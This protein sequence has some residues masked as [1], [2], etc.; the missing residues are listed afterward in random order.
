MKKHISLSRKK[1]CHSLCWTVFL[2]GSLLLAAILGIVTSLFAITAEASAIT[3]GTYVNQYLYKNYLGTPYAPYE[4]QTTGGLNYTNG[5]LSQSNT[6]TDPSLPGI[7]NSSTVS[8]SSN[9]LSLSISAGSGMSSGVSAQMWDTLNFGIPPTGTVNSNTVIGTLN[10]TVNTSIG[11]GHYDALITKYS[12]WAYNIAS[13]NSYGNNCSSTAFGYCGGYIGVDRQYVTAHEQYASTTDHNLGPFNPGTSTYSV[14]ITAGSL[15][16]GRVAYIAA[17]EASMN[18][19][20]NLTSPPF[21]IDP[22]ITISGLLPGVTVTSDSGYNYLSVP[23]P[24]PEPSTILLFGTGLVLIGFLVFKK[25][26]AASLKNEM[27]A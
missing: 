14:P 13:F 18:S 23:S 3:Y 25:N 21:S 12:L 6:L 7:Y 26:R 10:M 19:A 8:L 4:F 22:S 24:V 15:T 11:Q 27:A 1:S 16:N 5:T 2:N 20:F 17:I 9:Q